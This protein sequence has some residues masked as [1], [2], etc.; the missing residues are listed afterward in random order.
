MT[1]I[2]S[3]NKLKQTELVDR[4]EVALGHG[5]DRAWLAYI[6]GTTTENETLWR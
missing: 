5:T 2:F 1:I 4:H 6:L 3:E